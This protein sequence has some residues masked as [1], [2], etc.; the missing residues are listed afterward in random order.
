[1]SSQLLPMTLLNESG[2]Y[3]NYS[4]TLDQAD[5]NSGSYPIDFIVFDN[6]SG[7]N[8]VTIPFVVSAQYASSSFNLIALFGGMG[9]FLIFLVTVIGTV[10]GLLA[11]H[12][13]GSE[14]IDING[15]ILKGKPG[16]DLKM[17]KK[18]KPAAP[19]HRRRF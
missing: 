17:T 13:M 16:G 2:S 18:R 4:I 14:T 10:G 7:S 15:T 3:R 9:N 12:G 8:S 11:Y 1:M 6:A 5:Y 19:T